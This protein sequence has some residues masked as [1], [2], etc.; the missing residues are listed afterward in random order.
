[1]LSALLTLDFAAS[2]MNMIVSFLLP[3]VLTVF[4]HLSLLACP[5]WRRNQAFFDFLGNV[6]QLTEIVF[7]FLKRIFQY[8]LILHLFS[9]M[10]LFLFFAIEI[11]HI[12]CAAFCSE[13]GLFCLSQSHLLFVPKQRGWMCSQRTCPD[14][15]SSFH[16][17]AGREICDWAPWVPSALGF[18]FILRAF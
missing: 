5:L 8:T 4:F 3:V 9:A 18:A 6:K 13:W 11:L 17:L 15:S 2:V 16:H 7:S 1:M 12:L 10:L 14:F